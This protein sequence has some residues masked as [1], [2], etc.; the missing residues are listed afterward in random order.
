MP[1]D[2]NEP[3]AKF[4]PTPPSPHFPPSPALCGRMWWPWGEGG[5][6]GRLSNRCSIRSVFENGVNGPGHSESK[7][8]QNPRLRKSDSKTPSIATEFPRLK[9]HQT[10]APSMGGA[11]GRTRWATL[12]LRR[13]F[14]KNVESEPEVDAVFQNMKYEPSSGPVFLPQ[15]VDRR[16]HNYYPH[17]IHT[18]NHLHATT[19]A[20]GE[21]YACV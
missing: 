5:I 10:L 1:R 12:A 19:Q 16:R 15:A 8:S 3:S 6:T 13:D 17:S 9:H 20:G 14:I 7:T 11:G 18:T 21:V 4:W 2:P